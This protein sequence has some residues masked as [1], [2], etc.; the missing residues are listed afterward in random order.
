MLPLQIPA[1]SPGPGSPLS[2]V[3]SPRTPRADLF[4]PPTPRV[5]VAFQNAF[6]GVDTNQLLQ[7]LDGFFKHRQNYTVTGSAAL[8]LHSVITRPNPNEALPPSG[9]LDLIVSCNFFPMLDTRNT[10]AMREFHLE[11]PNPEKS[12]ILRWAPPG[13]PPIKIDIIQSNEDVVRNLQ[14]HVCDLDN[15]KT[16][17]LPALLAAN[18]TRYSDPEEIRQA[19]GQEVVKAKKEAVSRFFGLGNT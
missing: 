19:G 1:G 13:Q 9:D 2:N 10:A 5:R 12:Q 18:E 14:G 3:S 4:I 15:V 11:R 7:D 8:H 6:P 17:T 16:C